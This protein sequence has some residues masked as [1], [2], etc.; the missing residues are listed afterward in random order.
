[1]AQNN[2]YLDLKMKATLSCKLTSSDL[3]ERRLT[4]IAELKK[5][6]VSK[7]E[8]DN[9]Y[10]Y[11]FKDSDE[12]INQLVEFIKTERLCCNFFTFRLKIG[13]EPGIV[14]LRLS[15]PDGTKEF[16]EFELGM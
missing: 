15:G 4:V 2:S 16:I 11:T 1:M 5:N 10:I 12:M 13:E 14:A 8:T 7:N 6:L 9:G 3:Q